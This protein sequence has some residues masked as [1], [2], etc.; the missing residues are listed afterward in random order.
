MNMESSDMELPS[1]ESEERQPSELFTLR[2]KKDN[3][4]EL[5]D[6]ESNRLGELE[7]HS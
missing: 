5:T 4:E 1:N 7:S 6:E 2:Q 3:G